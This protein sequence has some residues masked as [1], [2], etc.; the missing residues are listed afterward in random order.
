V[1]V[2]TWARNDAYAR[3]SSRTCLGG[4]VLVSAGFGEEIRWREADRLEQAFE[5][6]CDWLRQHGAADRLAADAG[7]VRPKAHA[8][9][10]PLDAAFPAGRLYTDQAQELIA[11]ESPERLGPAEVGAPAD[12]L[13]C[14]GVRQ[15]VTSAA[16]LVERAIVGRGLRPKYCSVYQRPRT[17]PARSMRRHCHRGTAPGHIASATGCSTVDTRAFAPSG[18]AIGD[19][20][21][22]GADPCLTKGE[23]NPPRTTGEIPTPAC[24]TGRPPPT[25]ASANDT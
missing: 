23:G 7:D 20:T 5:D 9:Y 14:G 21:I 24:L 15:A 25:S 10:V 6:R 16:R 19:K 17:G 4:R 3:P 2:S 18:V 22:A 12:G 13:C 1:P 8:A 11:A